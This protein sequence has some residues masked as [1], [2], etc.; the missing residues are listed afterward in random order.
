MMD[1]LLHAHLLSF[2]VSVVR[3]YLFK[4]IIVEAA[5]RTLVISVLAQALGV[6][7]G[8]LA[9]VA[10][11]LRI[12]VAS[13]LASVY[14][15]FF[16][17]TPLLLQLLFWFVAVPQLAPGDFDIG[18]F[19]YHHSWFLFSP[20]QAALIGLALN[21][22]AYMAEIVRAGI[23]SIEAG[24][25]DASKALG[26]TRIQAM[27]LVI[28]PQSVR[29]IVPPTGNEFISMLKNSS[30]ASVV[31]YPEL[32]FVVRG[33]YARNYKTLE[34][35]TVAGIWYLFFT[36]V[37][38]VLQAELEARLRPEEERKGL[39]AVL[40]RAVN[41]PGEWYGRATGDRR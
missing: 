28:L 38:S 30:L 36:S 11:N 19:G 33:Q 13:Q 29:V 40:S 32:L 37:F 1:T 39:M 9:A 31:S 12:P 35:V 24:Q 25:M 27:R 20:F 5:R 14:V 10:R 7:L 8:I 3:E 15:W 6:A 22:G 34:L 18:P 4:D 21:E 41:P 23:E 26:M 17:G 2:D 16:R